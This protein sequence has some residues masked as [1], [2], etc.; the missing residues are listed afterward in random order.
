MKRTAIIFIFSLLITTCNG[1]TKTI[2][3]AKTIIEQAEAMG[4][5]L[6]SKDFSSFSKYTYPM[7][8]VMMGGKQVFVETLERG[9]EEMEAGGTTISKVI[10]GKP[11]QII[12]EENELQCTLSQEIEM[13]VPNGRLVSKSTLIAISTDNGENWYFIDTSGKD[14]QTMKNVLPNLSVNLV[15]PR[16]QQPAFYE[17]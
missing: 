9:Y 16:Q 4:L 2:D 8:I 10:F 6:L 13:K 15:I 1:Q 12:T 14:F 5:L 11:S 7:I 3:H 17:K